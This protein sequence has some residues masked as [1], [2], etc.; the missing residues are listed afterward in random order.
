MTGGQHG[1]YMNV[2]DYTPS[3]YS[4]WLE[5]YRAKHRALEARARRMLLVKESLG[6]AIG[7]AVLLAAYC[8]VGYVEWYL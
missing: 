2:Q 8:V 7:C 6:V 5:Y 1:G 3:D 4:N